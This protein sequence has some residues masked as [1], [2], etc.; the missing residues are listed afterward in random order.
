MISCVVQ[1]LF[2]LKFTSMLVWWLWWRKLVFVR[3]PTGK[4]VTRRCLLRVPRHNPPQRLTR[5]ARLS[6][7]RRVLIAPPI[8]QWRLLLHHSVPTEV[9]AV[10]L[11]D[12][13]WILATNVKVF[14]GNRFN[15][16]KMM[17]TKFGFVFKHPAVR[18]QHPLPRCSLVCHVC[19][20]YKGYRKIVY[21]INVRVFVEA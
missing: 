1:V 3:K 4:L 2:S 17:K 18:P 10:L 5:V 15:L 6:P 14:H 13:V 21:N 11:L 12:A 7:S 16:G 20:S 19:E 8:P 9:P